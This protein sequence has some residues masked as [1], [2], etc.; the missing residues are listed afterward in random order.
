MSAALVSERDFQAA[1]VE[2]AHLQG[3]RTYHTHDSRR[4]AA[5]F[6]D[7]TLAR[8]SR[9]VFVELKS[10]RGR[11]TSDQR[12]WL[13]ALGET[14]AEV[15]VWRPADWDRIEALLARRAA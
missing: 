7:L 15:Y 14:P 3:W 2:L 13:D 4:S 11:V 9:L 1:V 5:G 8:G 12:G 10:E 6:P